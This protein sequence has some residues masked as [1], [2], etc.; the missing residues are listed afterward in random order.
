M[1]R[2]DSQLGQGFPRAG[3]VGRFTYC[4]TRATTWGIPD[5]WDASPRIIPASDFDITGTIFVYLETNIE[6]MS[7]IEQINSS[8]IENVDIL[9]IERARP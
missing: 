7:N 9:R 3:S 1:S 2:Q 8:Y 5:F 6:T 4:C